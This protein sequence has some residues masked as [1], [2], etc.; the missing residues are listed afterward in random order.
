MVKLVSVNNGPLASNLIHVIGLKKTRDDGSTIISDTITIGR[1]GTTTNIE[2]LVTSKI[3]YGPSNTVSIAGNVNVSMGSPTAVL[4]VTS[5]TVAA[6]Y[7]KIAYGNGKFVII[8]DAL[9]A[10]YS[11]TGTTWTAATPP[12]PAFSGFMETII[13]AKDRFM[14]ITSESGVFTS[15]DGNTWLKLTAS[16]LNAP[17]PSSGSYGNDFI[18][19]IKNSANLLSVLSVST[20]FEGTWT[21]VTLSPGTLVLTASVFGKMSTTTHGTNVF[22]VFGKNNAIRRTEGL[23]TGSWSEPTTYPSISADWGFGGFGNDTFMLTG[24]IYLTISRD[25]GKTW[26]VPI[27]FGITLRA[28]T[29]VE[30]EWYIFSREQVIMISKDNGFTWE[31]RTIPTNIYLA[32]YGNGLIVGVDSVGGTNNVINLIG[33][34][35]KRSDGSTMTSDMNTIGREG[36]NTTLVGNTV[37]LAGN[38]TVTAGN[39]T[40]LYPFT[41]FS[42]PALYT[43]VAYGNGR[44]VIIGDTAKAFYS[45][46]GTTWVAATPPNPTFVGAMRSVVYAK[47]NFMIVTEN[48]PSNVYTSPDGISWTPVTIPGTRPIQ[49]SNRCVYGNNFVVGI[50]PSASAT[51][52]S[53][54]SDTTGTVW[55]TVN[56]SVSGY[57]VGFGAMRDGTNVFIIVGT[58]S[59]RRNAGTTLGV[60][61]T[62]GSWAA[63]TTTQ[64]GSWYY[65]GFGNDTFMVTS[66]DANGKLTISRDGGLTWSNPIS[67]GITLSSS[68]Y[69]D[70]EWFIGSDSGFM[71]V[72]RNDGL[73]WEKRQGPNIFDFVYGNGLIVSV[74]WTSTATNVTSVISLIKKRE[75][76][77][78]ITSDAITIGREG[79]A[80]TIDMTAETINIGTS[81]GAVTLGTTSATL[82]GLYSS[83]NSITIGRRTIVSG[84][85]N[86]IGFGCGGN[87]GITESITSDSTGNDS[88]LHAARIKCVSSVYQSFDYGANGTIHFQVKNGNNWGRGI[89][90]EGSYNSTMTINGSRVG[91]GITIPTALLD[92]NGDLVYGSAAGRSDRR[93]KTNIL[94]VE[95]QQALID[96]RRLKPKTYTYKD[97]EK[98]GHE[99]VYGFI[100]Q[101]VKEVLNYAGVLTKQSIPNIYEHVDFVNDI[102]TF[103]TFNTSSLERDA[104]GDIFPRI[105]LKSIC[106][107][108]EYLTIIEVLDEHTLKVDTS[109]W[110]KDASG[111]LIGSENPFVYGQ[112]VN[113][114]HTLNKDAIWTVATAALQEVDRQLQAEKQ[115]T[116]TMQTALDALLERVLALESKV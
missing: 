22:L 41:S 111:Q 63:P 49:N 26:S 28:P 67:F 17:A 115:K 29:Y 20:N 113:D 73:T 86:I 31:K 107:I 9:K 87:G 14:I 25:A 108:D 50:I 45:T 83:N 64:S 1:E 2:N 102:L 47:D 81:G 12:T 96:L 46:N 4:S 88:T 89:L 51:S 91:V 105:Q 109:S 97:T 53:V 37:S 44:F 98:R 106:Q 75:D 10:F 23:P 72:S 15:S 33:L 76:G 11:T 30:G 8:G 78:A 85:V 24:G 82:L 68:I 71:M 54:S 18:V 57:G 79:T 110:S 92:V 39:P 66:N 19:F 65:I 56:L 59:I 74:N 38:V 112:E 42:L 114:F 35:T 32:A 13:Y 90:G 104:S 70:G 69:A 84:D 77:S 43:R 40:T 100:A 27:N 55:G 21:S 6:Q 116:A 61:T 93:I 60:L 99:R 36:T 5:S 58:N 94:D 34:K 3:G 62:S 7:T 16:A 80:K 95:D 103:T 48:I 101:E 52:V